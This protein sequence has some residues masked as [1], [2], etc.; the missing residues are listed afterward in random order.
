METENS[1]CGGLNMLGPWE[2]A[3]L[4][5]LSLHRL[6]LQ[7]PSAQALPSVE[8]SFPPGYLQKRVFSWLPSNQDKKLSAPSLPLCL[9]G[10]CRAF[11][12]DENG[13]NL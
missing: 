12:H 9:P 7:S 10:C 11:H 3:L 6:A 1:R 8:E 2:V 13:L 5:S 4:G